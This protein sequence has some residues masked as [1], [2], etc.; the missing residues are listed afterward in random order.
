VETL[1]SEVTI[2]EP[3]IEIEARAKPCPTSTT[4]ESSVVFTSELE[5]PQA[6]EVAPAPV[7]HSLLAEPESLDV[8][9]TVSQPETKELQSELEPKAIETE[10]MSSPVKDKTGVAVGKTSDPVPVLTTP[11]QLHEAAAQEIFQPQSNVVPV[12]KDDRENQ[13]EVITSSTKLEEFSMAE[14]IE[15]KDIEVSLTCS[16]AKYY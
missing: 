8:K 4:E 2:P 14:H 1:V 6:M 5:T 7:A 10:S 16:F 15:V 13:A 11:Q 9:N 12:A 3:E